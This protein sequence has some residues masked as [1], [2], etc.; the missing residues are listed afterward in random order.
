M[1]FLEFL[2]LKQPSYKEKISERKAIKLYNESIHNIDLKYPCWRGMK[3]YGPFILFEGEKGNRAGLAKMNIHNLVYDYTL[4]NEYPKRCKSIIAITFGGKNDT[5]IYGNTRY[6]ILPFD[7]TL[8]GLS[9]RNDYITT[10][11]YNFHSKKLSNIFEEIEQFLVE[12][13]FKSFDELVNQTFEELKNKE[14][15][16][17][18]RNDKKSIKDQYIKMFGFKNTNTKIITSKDLK[19]YSEHPGHEVWMGGKCLAIREDYFSNFIEKIQ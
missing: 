9:D 10:E 4:K 11:N 7:D 5:S 6:A 18:P 14:C 8:I 15:D 13:K 16:L 3:D 17:F 19:K 1:K 12:K 2:K